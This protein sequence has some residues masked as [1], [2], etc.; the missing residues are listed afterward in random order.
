V[1]KLRLGPAAPRCCCSRQHAACYT[2]LPGGSVTRGGSTYVS[3]GGLVM[4]VIR[5]SRTPGLPRM[6]RTAVGSG[7]GVGEGRPYGSGQEESGAVLCCAVALC[8]V[9]MC[10]CMPAA[11]VHVHVYCC[12]LQGG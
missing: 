8:N 2:L 9:Y 10:T 6:V 11:C 4:R 1:P 7:T 5:S 3:E 12:M